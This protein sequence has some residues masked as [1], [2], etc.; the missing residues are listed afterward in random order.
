MTLEEVKTIDIN[1]LPEGWR[2]EEG[3]RTNKATGKKRIFILNDKGGCV[4]ASCT[5]CGECSKEL[6]KEYRRNNPEK[7]KESLKMWYEENREKMLEYHKQYHK[8]T[9][10]N[11]REKILACNKKWYEE[12]KEKAD[13]YYLEYRMKNKDKISKRSGHKRRALKK[14]SGGSFTTEQLNHCLEFFNNKCA[15]TGEQLGE[16]YDIDHIKPISKGGTSYIFNLVPTTPTAN[17][18]KSNK[19]LISWY[20]QQPYYSKE[21]LN[22]IFEWQKLAYELYGENEESQE[23]D[24]YQQIGV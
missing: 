8:K 21:R 2:V 3:R 12:N 7:V 24:Q 20:K 9:Y 19:D 23:Q 18:C 1:N 16:S 6:A 10:A 11:N 13:I 5:R 17:R 15:Y 14:A 4:G 22:K